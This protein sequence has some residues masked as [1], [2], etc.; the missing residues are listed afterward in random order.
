MKRMLLMALSLAV[1]FLLASCGNNAVSQSGEGA[2]NHTVYDTPQT[3]TEISAAENVPPD[4][5]KSIVLYFS[6][7]ETESADN[8]TED[9]ENS[10]V[11]IGGEALG[12]TQYVATLIQ[13]QTGA[14]IFRIEPKVPYP[15]GHDALVDRARE[16]QAS[17]ARPALK[18][19][20]GALESYDRIFIGYPIWWSDLPM[21]LYTLFDENDFSGK[22]MIP[23]ITHGGSGLAG[24]VE[25]IKELEPQAMVLE[26]AFCV[27]RNKVQDCKDGLAN[28][29]KDLGY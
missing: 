17:N 16:E 1:P 15:T 6:M 13:Q 8:M 28:W 2:N 19:N 26:P 22:E 12:N 25:A 14:D 24:T 27:S 3:V 23:F 9:E 11:I 29:L 4:T 7:P 18:E 20:V 5:P 10:V 21:L